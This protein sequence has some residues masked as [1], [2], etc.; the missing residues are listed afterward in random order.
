M[1]AI[2]G[3][4]RPSPERPRRNFGVAARR[5]EAVFHLQHHRAAQ[6][7]KTEH[8]IGADHRQ[9]L[10][11]RVGQQIPIDRF[12]ERLVD[13]HPVLVNR[14]PL[15]RPQHRR[16]DE[17]AIGDIRLKRIVLIVVDGDAGQAV[18]QG[19][20]CVG[21]PAAGEVGGAQGLGRA[22]GFVDRDA[23][24][25]QGSDADHDEGVR[26][27][28]VRK[29]GRRRDRGAHGQRDRDQRRPDA[30][31]VHSKFPFVPAAE[32]TCAAR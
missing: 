12:A 21:R 11:R 16:G 3:R 27:R 15:R 32:S 28:T 13:P 9:A 19:A 7:V 17:A 2:A 6:G 5:R 29:L 31:I 25:G 1:A 20:G 24:A 8:R 23:G 18:R 26:R 22:G 14:Q 10:D 4:R 30:A